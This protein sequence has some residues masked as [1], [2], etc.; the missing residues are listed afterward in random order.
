MV[1]TIALRLDLSSIQA[2]L[3]ELEERFSFLRERSEALSVALR[4]ESDA[5]AKDKAESQQLINELKHQ[6]IAKSAELE[7][8]RSVSSTAADRVEVLE[9]E[10]FQVKK[11]RSAQE[12]EN[13]SLTQQVADL[14]K[15]VDEQVSELQNVVGERNARV[16]ENQAMSFEAAKLNHQL[17]AL[18]HQL[19]MKAGELQDL[20]VER[21][22]YV[23]KVKDLER[24]V[25]EVN[26]QLDRALGLLA[27]NESALKDSSEAN[28]LTEFQL[29][30]V[31]NELKHY[32]LLSRK[33]SQVL[34]SSEQI[35]KR[36]TALVS[37]V[38][39]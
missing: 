21:D 14:Q 31:Q 16:S 37:K 11:E 20:V 23:L 25:L 39:Q 4:V 36:V 19:D 12:N 29:Q 6:E 34:S 22:G 28:E 17:D 9:A 35:T 13:A 26:R 7:T 33:Q 3:G 8:L 38:M 5:R 24:Q 2:S 18:N 15:L 1:V 32:F 10:L 27:T 30:Q